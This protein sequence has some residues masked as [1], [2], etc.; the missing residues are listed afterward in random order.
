[1]IEPAHPNEVPPKGWRWTHKET[2]HIVSGGSCDDL[3]TGVRM[4]LL[5]NNYPVPRELG[6][7]VLR[8]LD[9]EIQA[10][11]H[12]R[13]L[14]PYQL[15]ITTE[16]PTIAQMARSFAHAA[17]AWAASGFKNVSQEVYEYRLDRCENGCPFWQ[18]QSAFGY[19][20]CG[21]CGCGGLKLFAATTRCPLD[22]PRWNAI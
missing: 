1:M 6:Q 12:K 16:K 11:M 22:P 14:A 7:E 8:A 20:K 13:G 2:G 4:F 10:D 17:K 19:G 3:L 18:G 15:L 21:K 5:N 9:E